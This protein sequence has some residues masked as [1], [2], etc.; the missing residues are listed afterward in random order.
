MIF[1]DS[2]VFVIDLRYQRDEHYAINQLFISQTANKYT[3]IFNVLEVCGILSHNLSSQSLDTLYQTFAEWFQVQILYPPMSREDVIEKTYDKIRNKMGF[4]DALALNVA[5]TNQVKTFV[6]WNAKHFQ[7]KSG[8]P[9]MTPEQ[10][11]K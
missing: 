11:L 2:D 3:S 5:E 4:G 9:V 7:G 8:I 10:F 1:L 6:S